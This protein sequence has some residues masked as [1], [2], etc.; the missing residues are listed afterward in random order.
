MQGYQISSLVPKQT[1]WWTQGQWSGTDEKEEIGQP[2]SNVLGE[3]VHNL[4]AVDDNPCTK[5]RTLK[6]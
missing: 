4:H 2:L 5:V 3:N 6:Y 1:H